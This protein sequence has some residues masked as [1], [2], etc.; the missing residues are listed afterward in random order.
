VNPSSSTGRIPVG[1]LPSLWEYTDYRAWFN[2]LFQV[3]KATQRWFSY[4][5]LAKRAGFQARD[6]L[7][8]VMRGERGLSLD[9]AERL[10]DALGLVAKEKEYF[11]RLVEFNQARN[12]T[13]REVAWSR[14]QHALTRAR[15]ATA[16]RLLTDVHKQILASWQHLAVRSLIEMTP[17]PGDWEAL[18]K[19]LFPRR[20]KAS[21]GRSVKLLKTAGLLEKRANGYWYATDKSMA[22]PPEVGILAV[23]K[24]HRQCLNLAMSSIEGA[25]VGRR[26]LTGVMLGIS[27]EGYELICNRLSQLRDELVQLAEKDAKADRLYQLSL[28]FFPISDLESAEAL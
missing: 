20:S 23:R 28:S 6:Y 22:T 16:P 8:R 18:G 27:E 7:L 17:D 2:D 19:R 21:I 5:Y 25:P 12:D 24:F 1:P 15:A 11:L 26:N 14:M 3:R 4:G 10:A 9:G 13:E